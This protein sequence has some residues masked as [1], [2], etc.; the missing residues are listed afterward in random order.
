MRKRGFAEGVRGKGLRARMSKVRI[1]GHKSGSSR[2]NWLP[3][4]LMLM[5]I[6][7][8]F[9]RLTVRPWAI[10]L[11]GNL[12]VTSA[13]T[14]SRGYIPKSRLWNGISLQYHRA[15]GLARKNIGEKLGS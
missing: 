12:V 4:E 15:P 9:G 14:P 7:S 8:R 13:A 10:S 1:S 2:H 6:L 11:R 3:V 5:V